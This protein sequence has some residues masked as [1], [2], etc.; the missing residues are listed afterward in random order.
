[1]TAHDVNGLPPLHH[2]LVQEPDHPFP[3]DEKDHHLAQALAAVV[4]DHKF[5]NRIA[6]KFKVLNK[7]GD[8][9]LFSYFLNSDEAECVYIRDKEAGYTYEG[10]IESFSE[11]ENI[12]EVVLTNVKVYNFSES[13]YL[14]DVPRMYISQEPGRFAIESVPEN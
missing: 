13:E 11:G 12:Q 4:L 10:L 2:Q 5:I 8:E 9:Y 14:Y 7:Y 1:M 6:L 3:T